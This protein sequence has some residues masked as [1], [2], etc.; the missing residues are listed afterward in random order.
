MCCTVTLEGV[1]AES[2]ESR[3]ESLEMT[4]SEYLCLC[5]TVCEQLPMYLLF[6]VAA[7][8]PVS[9]YASAEIGANQCDA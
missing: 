2:L 4:P 1:T 5:L 6:A 9:F 7:G 8:V 3:A